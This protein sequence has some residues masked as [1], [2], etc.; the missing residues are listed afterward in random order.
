MRANW[1][2]VK[3]VLESL[4]MAPSQ[5]HGQATAGLW[6]AHHDLTPLRVVQLALLIH[7]WKF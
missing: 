2:M 7:I 5:E 1:H 6:L 3:G 4:A